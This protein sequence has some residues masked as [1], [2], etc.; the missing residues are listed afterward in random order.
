MSKQRKNPEHKIV[1]GIK[2]QGGAVAHDGDA[3]KRKGIKSPEK[4]EA[5]AVAV[6]RSFKKE[7]W[8][9][10]DERLKKF[11]DE[12]VEDYEIKYMNP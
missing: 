2:W 4:H 11:K 12:C 9:T 5:I 3:L 8:F 7:V 6:I 1:T 10:S